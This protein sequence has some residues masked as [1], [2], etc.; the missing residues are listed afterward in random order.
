MSVQCPY[1]SSQNSSADSRAVIIAAGHFVRRCD[2]SKH[3]RYRCKPCNKTFSTASFHPFYKQKKRHLNT[4]VF[5][6]YA[7]GVSLRRMARL[8]RVNRKTVIRKYIF[9]GI[10]AHFFLNEDRQNYPL[11]TKLSLMT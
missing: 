7:S 6:L 3:Q 9:M 11:A 4:E 2:S 10:A 8:F 5:K 1:C